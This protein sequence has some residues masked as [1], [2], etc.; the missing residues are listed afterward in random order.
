MISQR[1]YMTPAELS[2]YLGGSISVRT[3]ANWRS[4]C[5]GPEYVKIGGKVRYKRESIDQWLERNTVNGT[6]QYRS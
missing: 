1:K 4:Q 2:E 6:G 5:I 3:M